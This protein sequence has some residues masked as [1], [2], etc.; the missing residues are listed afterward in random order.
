MNTAGRKQRRFRWTAVGLAVALGAGGLALAQS[1]QAA[2][3]VNTSSWY[4][5][6]NAGSGKALDLYNWSTADGGEFRQWTRTDAVN[7]QFQ[8]VSSG[9]GYYRLKNRHSGKVLDV[10]GRSTADG[11]EI[12]QYTDNNGVNQQWRLTGNDNSAVR[13]INRNSGKALEVQGGS[14]ADGADVTQYT[15]WGGSNQTWRLTAVGS[16]GGTTTTTTSSS[17]GC[18]LPS[19]YRWSSTGSLA[20]PKSGWV[21]LKDF[22]N[23]VINGK[24]LVYATNHDTGSGWGSMNFSPSPTGPTWP[25]P[26]RTR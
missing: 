4:V 22:T 5:L 23:V 14:T 13:F 26:A 20:T 21:S 1:A 9:D 16:G 3:S 17:G 7:Q 24:H 12:N 18:S 19:T 2:I 8:F 11:A 15:D 6:V 25:R 10:W